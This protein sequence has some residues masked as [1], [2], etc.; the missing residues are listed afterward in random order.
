PMGRLLGSL[1]GF[2][3]AEL[4]GFAIKAALER[5]GVQVRVTVAAGADDGRHQVTLHARADETEPWTVH[6]TGSLTAQGEEP[7]DP[8][9]VVWPPAGA[10]PVPVED[11]Y[12]ALAAT[13]MAYGPAFRGLRK[14]WRH[15]AEVLAEVGTEEAVAGYALHPALFDAALHAVGAGGL[16][17]EHGVR[18]PFEFAGVRISGEAGTVLRVRL[19]PGTRPDS[20]RVALADESG[21]PVAEVEQLTLR[22]VSGVQLSAAD[23]LLYGVE[24]VPEET[25]VSAEPRVTIPLGA[26]LPAPAPVVTVDATAP[27]AAGERAAALLTL[28][29]TWFADPARADSRL[30]VRTSGAVGEEITDADGAALWGLV[31]SAQAEH[32][33]RIHLV[34]AAE[35]L[36]VPLPEALIRDGVVRV[37]RLARI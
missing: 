26:V 6:A 22:P 17:P 15:G 16:L 19:T 4:G 13:G 23:R 2:S 18:L 33:D 5:A 24:W 1:K 30:V 37:P 36:F 11:F 32:P 14:V 7:A 10:E 8:G 25:E 9:L 31:R 28:L 20:V 21:L 12:P 3:G 29:Q 27:G 34:D 35:E